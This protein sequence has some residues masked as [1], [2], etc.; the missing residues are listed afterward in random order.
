MSTQTTL[1]GTVYIASCI[2]NFRGVSTPRILDTRSG[3]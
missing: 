2:H 3:V 1:Q